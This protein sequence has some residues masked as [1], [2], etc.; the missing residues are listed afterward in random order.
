M[1][2]D[3]PVLIVEVQGRCHTGELKI[4]LPIGVDRAHI[5]PVSMVVVGCYIVK[6][7]GEH[8]VFLV[9]RREDVP[10]EVMAGSRGTGVFL[11]YIY[12]K[13]DGEYIDPHGGHGHVVLAGE[14]PGFRWFLLE[15]GYS[16]V[17]VYMYQTKLGCAFQRHLYTADRDIRIIIDMGRSHNTVVHFV[18]MISRQDQDIT[19]FVFEYDVQVLVHGVGRSLVPEGCLVAFLGGQQLDEFTEFITAKGPGT[20]HMTDQGVGPVL[21]QDADL[22]DTGVNTIGEGKIYNPVFTA[23][24]NGQ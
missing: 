17:L 7:T 24:R 21:R 3:R 5:A 15:T 23:E 20:F 16:P 10:A 18:D 9:D 4:G 19:G 12:K 22:V 6:G 2:S 13:I 11:K 14:G 8:P 1:G